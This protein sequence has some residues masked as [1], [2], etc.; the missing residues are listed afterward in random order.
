MCDKNPKSWLRPK[1][2][3]KQIENEIFSLKVLYIKLKGSLNSI[4]GL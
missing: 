4:M 2:K 3:K 1:E